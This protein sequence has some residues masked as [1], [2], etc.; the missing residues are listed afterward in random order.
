M[1]LFTLL[2]HNLL[3]RIVSALVGGLILL[4]AIAHSSYT[5]FVS[6][7][8]IIGFTQWELYSLFKI[9]AAH[10]PFRL[11]GLLMSV[12]LFT[13][14]FRW[15]R[16]SIEA[17]A[18]LWLLPLFF[19]LFL[20]KLLPTK[21]SSQMPFVDMALTLIGTVY[22]GGS[23]SIANWLVFKE[24]GGDYDPSLLLGLIL[25]VW[26]YDS[27][28]YFTGRLVGRHKIRPKI[29]PKK[30]WEGFLGGLL[31][32]VGVGLWIS[33]SNNGLEYWKWLVVAGLVAV[34]G[35]MGDLSESLLKRALGVKDSGKIMPGHGGLLDRV[36][37][38]MFV[39]AFLTPII[40]LLNK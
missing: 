3:Q 23:F 13:L 12:V 1:K 2:K 40:L 24:R 9:R 39:I 26:S 35:T 32:A 5:F 25:I 21:Q 30:S 11:G 36:D 20:R 38:L 4:G 34:V 31:A 16:G 27:G 15:Q 19:V 37:A 10:R 28:A 18:F 7:L 17:E 22:V 8:L 14:C 6:F 33:T 29:S